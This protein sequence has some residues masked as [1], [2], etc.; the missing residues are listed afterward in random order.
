M[1][2]PTPSDAH[3]DA[4]LTNISIA[5]FQDSAKYVASRAFPIVPVAKQS[6]V[7]F[8]YDQ[9]FWFREEAQKRAPSTESSGGGYEL[10]TDSYRAD[11][12][13]HHK[14]I[15]DQLVANADSPINLDEDA[16]RFVSNQ[17]LLTLE[18]E[19]VTAFFDTSIWTGSASG[20]DQT[21]V[22]G[23]PGTD[24]FRHW[25]DAASDPA[26]DIKL[27]MNEMEE[28]TGRRPN[29]MVIALTS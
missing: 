26:K 19:W 29:K 4:I 21:G 27:Y 20:N 23:A 8:T 15:S 18:R 10:D 3:V 14:D 28:K 25:D 9:D 11:V 6:D 22:G 17:L 2:Q 16:T 13:A 24:E 12:F 1:P 5:F 7:F